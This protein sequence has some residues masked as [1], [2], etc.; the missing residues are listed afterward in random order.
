MCLFW[1]WSI[2]TQIKQIANQSW[3]FN[4]ELIYFQSLLLLFFGA[5]FGSKTWLNFQNFWANGHIEKST[6]NSCACFILTLPRE[7]LKNPLQPLHTIIPYAPYCL[8]VLL[9]DFWAQPNWFLANHC[10]S[11]LPTP[12][13]SSSP[14][15]SATRTTAAT[16]CTLFFSHYAD[17]VCWQQLHRRLCWRPTATNHL[18]RPPPT[19]GCN[20]QVLPNPKSAP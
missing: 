10:P 18:W 16:P 4:L 2:Y 17:A 12:P 1:Y 14:P 15:P 20:H 3:P 13:P 7:P 8:W 5:F 9:L 11:L 6:I 19:T